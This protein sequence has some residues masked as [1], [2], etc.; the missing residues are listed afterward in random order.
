MM[1]V[2]R[3]VDTGNFYGD[4]RIQYPPAF[5]AGGYIS[6]GGGGVGDDCD[7]GGA[8]DESPAQAG[9]GRAV[10][11]ESVFAVWGEFAFSRGVLCAMRREGGKLR[12]CVEVIQVQ[13]MMGG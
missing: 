5:R 9:L 8:A 10:W 6:V 1:M 13:A 11:G 12:D 7:G 4:R 2:S 3:R